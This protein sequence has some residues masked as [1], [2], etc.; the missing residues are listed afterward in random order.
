MLRRLMEAH[1]FTTAPCPPPARLEFGSGAAHPE[2]LADLAT[3][4]PRFVHD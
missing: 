2:I 3:K 1:Y 4:H